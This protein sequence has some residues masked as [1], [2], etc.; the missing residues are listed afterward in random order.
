MR[1]GLETFLH[2]GIVVTDLT[3]AAEDFERRWGAP[4]VDVEEI[5]LRD[6]SCFGH[7]AEVSLKHGFIRHGACDIELIQPLSHSSAYSDFLEQHRGDSVHH[8]AYAVADIDTYLRRLRPIPAELV[9][10]AYL[11]DTGERVV[12]VDGFA[13]GPVVELIQRH[14]TGPG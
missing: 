3:G 7:P 5:V 8:L 13:H 4:V 6:A 11:P 10:D 14:P 12:Q 9:L 1:P 2:V